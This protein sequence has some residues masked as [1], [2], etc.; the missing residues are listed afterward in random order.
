MS[1]ALEPLVWMAFA[2]GVGLGLTVGLAV[3]VLLTE[4]RARLLTLQT[5]YT[6]TPSRMVPVPPDAEERMLAY[7][8]EAALEQGTQDLME[9]SRR[10]GT[11]LTPAEAREAAA[12]ALDALNR[13]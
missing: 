10:L 11:P 12:A 5:P 2:A 9:R 1:A 3:A 13:A 6:P 8:M 7:Q 4:R